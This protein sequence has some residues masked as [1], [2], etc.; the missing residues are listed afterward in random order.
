[1]RTNYLWLIVL[2]LL[3]GCAGIPDSVDNEALLK[4]EQDDKQVEIDMRNPDMSAAI[5][6]LNNGQP[7]V[8]K[9]LL[10]GLTQR[11]P[12]A[13]KP[14][15]NV[16]LISFRRGELDR[17]QQAAEKALVLQPEIAVADYLL[18]LIA[19]KKNDAPKAL[20]HYLA[21]LEKDL[22]HAHSHYNL[23]LLYDTYYQDLGN[24]VFHY[25]RYLELS[26]S[27]DE[28]TLSWVRELESQLVPEG[29]DDAS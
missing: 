17:A 4:N 3:T 21:A 9:A 27:D 24:A 16:G 28:V 6:A 5:S 23:A 14:W 12:L 10:L 20:A 25:R 8:A 15:V 18:G 19:H 11:Y 26:A 13:G 2:L 1:M 29:D 7:M 22:Q